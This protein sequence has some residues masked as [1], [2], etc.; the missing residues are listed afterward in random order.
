[1]A[2]VT[3]GR[4]PT[5]TAALQNVYKEMYRAMICKDIQSLRPLL[6]DEFYLLHMTGMKQT[7]EAYLL[8]IQDGTLNYYSAAHENISVEIGQSEARITGDSK[9]EA[10]VFGGGRH[11]WRLRQTMRLRRESGKWMICESIASTY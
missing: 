1:M 10:S 5:D 2:T 6:A 4:V 3:D 8:A 7:K 9:V 11:T